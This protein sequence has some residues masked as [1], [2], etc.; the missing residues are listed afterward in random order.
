[1]SIMFLIKI[2]HQEMIRRK[3]LINSRRL[4]RWRSNSLSCIKLFLEG[5]SLMPWLN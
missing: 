5:R 2:F 4:K 1:M 3:R